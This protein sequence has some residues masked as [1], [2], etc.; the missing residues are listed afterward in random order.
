MEDVIH[1]L[2]G[3]EEML[4]RSVLTWMRVNIHFRVPL[5][6]RCMHKKELWKRAHV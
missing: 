3:N 5:V 6:M 1:Q 2:K 4:K